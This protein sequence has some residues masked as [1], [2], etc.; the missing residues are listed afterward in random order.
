MKTAL[1]IIASSNSQHSR[2][3]DIIRELLACKDIDVNAQDR[4]G[5]TAL[6]MACGRG[7]NPSVLRE[8]LKH[9]EVDVNVRA[10]NG[11]N[12]M[13]IAAVENCDGAVKM[14]LLRGRLDINAQDDDGSSEFA[15]PLWSER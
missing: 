4:D 6:M 8:L 9:K 12:A 2:N 7:Y 1:M 15:M 13:M 5:E 10:N 3:G 14:L 11:R